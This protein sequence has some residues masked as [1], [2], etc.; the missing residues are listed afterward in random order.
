MT[1]QLR[2]HSTAQRDF[3][4]LADRSERECGNARTRRYL[5]EIERT[6]RSI[7]ENPMLGHDAQLPHVDLRRVTAGRDVIFF[8]FNDREVQIVRILHDRMDFEGRLK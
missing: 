4:N 1:R 2:Y 3:T 8:T 5:D 6:I 7:V